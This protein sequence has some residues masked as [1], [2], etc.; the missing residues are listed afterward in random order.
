MNKKIRIDL[1]G[2]ELLALVVVVG[3]ILQH[4]LHELSQATWQASAQRN[5]TLIE[6]LTAIE[7]VKTQG[8]ESVIQARWEQTNAYLAGINMRMRGLSST[9]L[10]ATAWLTQ[11]VSV[12]LIVI[13][14]YLIGDRQLTMGALIAATMLSG[15]AL[16][17]SGQI[18]GLLLQ[19]QGAVTALESLEKIMAQ[20]VE[21]PAGNAFIHRREL[22]GEIVFRDVHFA[23]PGRSDSALDGV[24]FK[25]AAGERV[26]LIG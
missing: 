10:S 26:A 11:L 25:L 13:G 14:V 23:Y 12:S 20:P 3:Y 16:S 7:T 2:C 8:A 24:S 4:R 5:A 6:S 21:R 1:I 15:R 19:Y 22:R 9:A 18:V 17:P